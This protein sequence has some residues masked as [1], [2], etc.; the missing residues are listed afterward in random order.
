MTISSAIDALKPDDRGAKREAPPRLRSPLSGPGSAGE[1]RA[2]IG[3]AAGARSPYS[4]RSAERWTQPAARFASRAHRR[5]TT[6]P[7]R[8]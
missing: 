7:I 4:S 3:T 6:P 1:L 2:A 8:P 5:P